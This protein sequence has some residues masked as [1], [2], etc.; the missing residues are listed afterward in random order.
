MIESNLVNL[1][2][3][4]G[5]PGASEK[6]QKGKI[7]KEPE[8][9]MPF[10]CIIGHALNSSHGKGKLCGPFNKG[11]TNRQKG[12]HSAIP[13]SEAKNINAAGLFATAASKD[14]GVKTN[15]SIPGKIDLL[16]KRA[17]QKQTEGKVENLLESTGIKKSKPG[18]NNALMKDVRGALKPGLNKQNIESVLPKS[19][20]TGM[21]VGKDKAQVCVKAD[22]LIGPF[23]KRAPHSGM[24]DGKNATASKGKR[25]KANGSIAGK[26]NLQSESGGQKQI[27]VEGK[28]LPGGGALKDSKTGRIHP[29]MEAAPGPQK[30]GLN[31][32]GIEAGLPN[33][34]LTKAVVG[35]DEVGGRK[36]EVGGQKSEQGLSIDKSTIN[37]QQSTIQRGQRAKIEDASELLKF[38]LK[39]A[40]AVKGKTAV[41]ENFRDGKNAAVVFRDSGFKESKAGKD[42]VGGQKSEVGGQKS[43]VGGRRSEV[44]GRKSEQG[45]SI[46]KSTINNQQS[47]IQ[48]GQGAKMVD[49]PVLLRSGLKNA[50][51]AKGKSAEEPGRTGEKSFTLI[52]DDSGKNEIKNILKHSGLK[53][54]ETIE[55]PHRGTPQPERPSDRGF[56]AGGYHNTTFHVSGRSAAVNESVNSHIIEPRAL[57]DQIANAAKMPG[58]VRI[59]L[60]PPRLGTLDV[61]VL[62]R[63]NKVHVILQTENNNVR[64][65]L[66]SNV[67]SLKSSLRNHG[68]VADTINVSVQEKSDGA[69]H[70]ADYRSGQNETLFKEGGNREGNEED[71]GGEQNSLN[72]DPSSF[73]EENQLVRSDG[74]VSLFA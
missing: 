29:L 23:G 50:A 38:S 14:K 5:L 44:G 12:Q 10:A 6:L 28:N 13:G 72:H 1:K 39:N 4:I 35:K 24:R 62:V 51:A 20:L 25:A 67:E 9:M 56:S 70:G 54:G 58:R 59:T 41:G 66:Q 47:T 53:S 46:D 69:D 2:Q 49:A 64:Q 40:D 63:D 57:I 11:N 31:K 3:D 21:V 36:S 43:E 37:N 16:S 74:R 45:L 7:G 18:I 8:Q 27:N 68:L 65:I 15:G 30:S 52:K 73:E 22:A 32:A 61:D 33:S 26:I 48:R 60:N 55:I 34:G 17:G 42:E 19:G 71:Q